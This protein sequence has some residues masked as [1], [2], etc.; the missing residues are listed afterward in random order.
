MRKF[1]LFIIVSALCL[2]S[3][4]AQTET[5]DVPFQR[6]FSITAD[7]GGGFDKAPIFGWFQPTIGLGIGTRYD[8]HPLWGVRVGLRYET[9]I[10]DK[11]EYY[12]NNLLIPVEMEFHRP[13]FYVQG[14]TFIGFFL[15][16]RTAANA[17]A[18][19]N[20]GATLGIGGRINLTQNDLLTIGVHSALK[21]TWD[22]V[23]NNGVGRLSE[24]VPNYS[25]M[26]RVGFEHR[27]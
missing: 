16:T 23:Y 10:V 22:M 15:A 20:I 18:V 11:G 5:Q 6:G 3:L 14:G 25:V 2:G 9:I 4:K 8:F 17:V 21:E 13:H 26:L 27:F 1:F 19:F 12:S 24:S 7:V